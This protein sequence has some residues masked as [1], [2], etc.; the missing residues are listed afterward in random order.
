MM[1]KENLENLFAE[2]RESLDHNEPASG[3]KERFFEKL[4]SERKSISTMGKGRTPWLK[5]LSIAAS[6][7]LI[8]SIGTY[9]T[10]AEPTIEEQVARI[11]PEASNS[12]FYFAN[13]IEEQVKKLK[14][15]GSPETKKI[16]DDTLLQLKKLEKDYNQLEQNLIQ[17][18]N[19]KLILS[20]MIT[21]FQTRMDLL[22]DVL[23]QIETIKIIKNNNNENTI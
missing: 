1:K 5:A 7:T 13:L 20:A 23:N 22:N 15:E 11:S 3:H 12:Q 4:N 17:G 16:I 8:I 2:L 10:N 19:S 21:N 14:K 9:I 6:L 18:G